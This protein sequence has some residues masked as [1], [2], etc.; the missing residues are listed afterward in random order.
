MRYLP[1]TGNDRKEMLAAIGAS[2][3]ADL[4]RD[5]PKK[6]R[7]TALADLP[8]HRGEIEVERA[9]SAYAA[10]NRSAGAGPFFSGPDAITTMSLR[11]SIISSSVPNS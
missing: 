3:V 5:V 9:L 2:S 10:Q 4:Y 11:A 7:M 8:L 6:A 1:L